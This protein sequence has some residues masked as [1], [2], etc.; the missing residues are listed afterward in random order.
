MFYILFNYG[1]RLVPLE[2]H[3]ISY[4]RLKLNTISSSPRD[5]YEIDLFFIKKNTVLVLL[6]N[7]SI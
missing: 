2:S 6:E 4:L 3:S 7:L 1:S 5:K